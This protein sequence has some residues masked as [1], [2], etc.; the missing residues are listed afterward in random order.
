[1]RE[2]LREVANS[3]VTIADMMEGVT[4]WEE[5]QGK[6][7]QQCVFPKRTEREEKYLWAMLRIMDNESASQAK[8]DEVKKKRLVAN[9]RKRMG[10]DTNQPGILDAL[11]LKKSSSTGVMPQP[12][13]GAEPQPLPTQ[14]QAKAVP[15]PSLTQ[16]K[17]HAKTDQ[18]EQS[19][20]LTHPISQPRECSEAF[21]R[22]GLVPEEVG[23]KKLKTRENHQ[24]RPA[25]E[26]LPGVV[27]GEGVCKF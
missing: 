25:V 22:I 19:N 9:A 2:L 7:V 21:A 10:A 18:T 26:H 1:M 3:A 4:E 11:K 15:Q 6:E 23:P 12:T 16:A 14:V 8:R 24:P 13:H 20:T 17:A 27:R 5:W